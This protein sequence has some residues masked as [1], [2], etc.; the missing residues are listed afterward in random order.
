MNDREIINH[1]HNYS[2][3]LP[4]ASGIAMPSAGEADQQAPSD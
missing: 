1:L 4:Y 3:P 2:E